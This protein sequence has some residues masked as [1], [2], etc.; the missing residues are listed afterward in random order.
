MV[1]LP[2][3]SNAWNVWSKKATKSTHQHTQKY[4]HGWKLLPSTRPV[5]IRRVLTNECSACRWNEMNRDRE[6]ERRVSC[7]KKM[8]IEPAR[9]KQNIWS[10]RI[11]TPQSFVI[12]DTESTARNWR[13]RFL[14]KGFTNGNYYTFFSC[15]Y[16]YFCHWSTIIHVIYFIM[17][18]F[19]LHRWAFRIKSRCSGQCITFS[20]FINIEKP[21]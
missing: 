4:I 17:L 16:L 2:K 12:W 18:V 11:S 1:C 20:L 8:G 19:C 5:V 15:L 14:L 7:K 9:P 3:M 10:K 21:S 13:W 6:R